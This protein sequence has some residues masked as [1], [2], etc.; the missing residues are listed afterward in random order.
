MRPTHRVVVVRM[1]AAE[2]VDLALQELGRLDVAHAIE[3]GHFVETAVQ[4]AF[5]GSAV[6]A[7]DVVDQRVVENLQVF[8]LIDQPTDVMIRVR[9]ERGVNLHLA[10][11]NRLQILRHVFVGRDFFGPLGQDRVG[12]DHSELLLTGEGLFTHL[13][14]ALVEFALVLIDPLLRHVMRRMRGAGREVHE[15]RLVGHQCFLLAHPADGLVRH[16]L[17]EVVALLGALALLHRR[18]AF[19]DRGIPLVRFAADEA[20]E[21]LEAAAAGGPL[22]ERPHRARLPDRHLVALAELCRRIAVE[23]E[24]HRERRLALR[25]HRGVTRSRRRDLADAAHVH[26]MVIAPREQR[27]ACG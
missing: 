25:Q 4:R 10:R 27:L 16:V 8:Q 15:E 9:E 26:R 3:H 20:V 24:R 18:G 13:V 21:V 12:G 5:C 22:A 17:G 14:P 1:R 6:V 23:L 2:V 19:I 7:E 11:E